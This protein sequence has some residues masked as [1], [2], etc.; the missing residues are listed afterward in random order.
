M[1][2]NIKNIITKVKP[3][4]IHRTHNI[5]SSHLEMFETHILKDAGQ[6]QVVARCTCSIAR[7]KKN[8]IK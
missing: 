7:H 4:Y 5:I 6:V 2:E 8:L 1:L 3:T